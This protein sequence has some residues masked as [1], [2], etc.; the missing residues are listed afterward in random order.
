MSHHLQV[1]YQAMWYI[2]IN[3]EDLG[4]NQKRS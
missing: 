4:E 2:S 3:L 1:P